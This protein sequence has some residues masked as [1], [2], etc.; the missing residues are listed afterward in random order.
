[1]NS[2]SLLIVYWPHSVSNLNVKMNII[3]FIW[4]WLMS[5]ILGETSA[6]T[7]FSI[8]T[9]RSLCLLC[10]SW[11]ERPDGGHFSDFS[12][13]TLFATFW[14]GAAARVIGR[15]ELS[16]C[17]LLHLIVADVTHHQWTSVITYFFGLHQSFTRLLWSPLSHLHV[18][19]ILRFM[20]VT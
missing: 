6:V 10:L 3:S 8:S 1:M 13:D 14:L 20:S 5:L 17:N 9:G 12:R 19:G 15:R 2:I 11:Q 16:K 7:H 4:L 18:V